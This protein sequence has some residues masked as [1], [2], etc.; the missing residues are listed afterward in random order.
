[1]E[2]S[3]Q[4]RKGR[5]E[6]N[7]LFGGLPARSR[8]G[9]GRGEAAKWKGSLSCQNMHYSESRLIKRNFES[10]PEGQ[11]FMIRSPSPDRIIRKFPQRS[12]RLCDE[13]GFNRVA[14]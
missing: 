3:P 4:R 14:Y 8:F 5:R 1:M 9:E 7:F 2:S 13:P 6:I 10:I 12:L 11:G